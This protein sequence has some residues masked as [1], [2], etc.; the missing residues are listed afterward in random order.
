MQ[1]PGYPPGDQ[2]SLKMG[3]QGFNL[4]TKRRGSVAS[5]GSASSHDN[6]EPYKFPSEPR[7]VIDQND[8][9]APE[10]QGKVRELHQLLARINSK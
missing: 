1:S 7:Q 10:V 6:Y 4:M 3:L 5:F 8:R 9:S 2:A